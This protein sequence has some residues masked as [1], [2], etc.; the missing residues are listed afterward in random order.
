M[1]KILLLEDD[2]ALN[3]GIRIALQQDGH[4]VQPC[5]SLREAEAQPAESFDLFLL[6][7]RLPDG[8][9]LAFCRSL[10]RSLQTPVLFLTANDTEADMLD[11]F[12]AGCDDYVAKPF[13]LEVLRQKIRA[14]LR[15]DGCDVFAFRGLT[16]DFARMRVAVDGA[17]C[18]LT[19]NE[20]RLLEYFVKNRGR[21]LTR[22]ML[23]E[24]L[25]DADGQFV[26]ENTLS[27]TIRRLRQKI[28]P[29]PKT[30]VYILT[31][32]GIGYTFGE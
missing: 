21:V 28:E 4:S 1:A 27:V 8:N 20:Y 24:K 10:R 25:W 29:D 26:D 31:V 12:H 5:F 14:M 17:E 16:V 2:N 9:G 18:R 3:N 13:S 32:F 15:R 30:P 23:L 6:D 11:G 7:V 19:A 22:T